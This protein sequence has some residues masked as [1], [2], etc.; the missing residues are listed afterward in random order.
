VHRPG[1]ATDRE[2]I[3]SVPLH[4]NPVH[5]EKHLGAPPNPRLSPLTLLSATLPRKQLGRVRQ[6][7]GDL[8]TESLGKT[9]PGEVDATES[10][11]RR[12]PLASVF[13]TLIQGAPARAALCPARHPLYLRTFAPPN[14]NEAPTSRSGSIVTRELDRTGQQIFRQPSS[15]CRADCNAS[16][17]LVDLDRSYLASDRAADRHCRRRARR[18]RRAA[19]SERI[20]DQRLND[21]LAV[22]SD[23]S[24]A[25]SSMRTRPSCPLVRASVFAAVP[26][27]SRAAPDVSRLAPSSA[28]G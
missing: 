15:E 24:A 11:S 8:D 25:N 12:R 21:L 20:R 17:S 16:A 18:R 4:G 27:S 10:A 13:A 22:C 2:A 19:A 28:R 1:R 6:P 5:H 9:P 23:R 14:S 3:G 26:V 7:S